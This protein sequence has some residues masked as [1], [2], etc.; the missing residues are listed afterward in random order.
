[1]P[2]TVPELSRA[3]HVAVG[4]VVAAGGDILLARRADHRHQGGLWEFPGGKVEA[5][6][7]VEQALHREL[8]EEL[9]IG[10]I[11]AEQLLVVDHDYGDR[12][13]RLDVWWVS[14]FTGVPRSLEAQ[15]WR[16]VAPVD[17]AGYTFPAA[18]API[19]EAVLRRS[20]AVPPRT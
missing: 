8:L 11:A 6:E 14:E 12:L 18:N 10:V 13:V 2:S 7:R 19:V 4:V 5:G 9:D 3:L 20:T 15:P 1:M 16:W 17:L